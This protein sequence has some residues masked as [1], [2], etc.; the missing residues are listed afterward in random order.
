[1][2]RIDVF[3]SRELQAAL[4]GVRGAEKAVQANIRKATK[5]IGM[6][7][8]KKAVAEQAETRLEHRVL[9]DTARLSVSNQNVRLSSA[10]VGRALSGGLK[11][12]ESYAAV[13]FGA[14]R[15]AKNTYTATSSKGKTYSVTRRTRAQLRPQRRKGY[16]V[17]P[18]A[19]RMIPRFA[20]LWVQV[21][22]KTFHDAIEGK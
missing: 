5:A 12:S 9:V 20:A 21:V 10:S 1:M 15:Q 13:E 17:Y 2:F 14:N 4:L 18:A 7:E 3:G 22:V 8:W 6:P 16:A 11:P 19:Q